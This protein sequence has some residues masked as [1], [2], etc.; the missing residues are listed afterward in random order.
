MDREDS[1]VPVREPPGSP[2]PNRPREARFCMGTHH[3]RVDG[4]FTGRSQK[5][6]LSWGMAR[7][8]VMEDPET[9]TEADD[10]THRQQAGRVPGLVAQVVGQLGGF[11]LAGPVGSA[12]TPVI[13]TVLDLA[14]AEVRRNGRRRVDAT[15]G[16]AA[17]LSGLDV[18]DLLEELVSSPPHMAVLLEAV[19]AAARTVDARVVNALGRCLANAATDGAKAEDETLIAKAFRELG[20]AHFRLVRDLLRPSPFMSPPTTPEGISLSMTL[21]LKATARAFSTSI[22]ASLTPGTPCSPGCSDTGRSRKPIGA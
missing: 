21:S 5:A 15:L 1:R 7:V 18:E 2:I 17:R 6:P 11:A 12:L 10:E 22:Q 4:G 3:P 13:T 9:N 14:I 20:P 16:E 19:E 8:P